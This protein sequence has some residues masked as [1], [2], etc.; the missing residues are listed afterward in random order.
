V[1]INLHDCNSPICNSSPINRPNENSSRDEWTQLAN[2]SIN[3][4]HHINH[5]TYKKSQTTIIQNA[6]LHQKTIKSEKILTNP[7]HTKLSLASKVRQSVRVVSTSYGNRQQ[8]ILSR[9]QALQ[10][11]NIKISKHH[12]FGDDTNSAKLNQ[13]WLGMSIPTIPM[14]T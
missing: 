7:I 1:N 12:Q 6:L 3:N 10:A 2:D 13:N 4:I 5:W 8:S 11:I 14:H 9:M